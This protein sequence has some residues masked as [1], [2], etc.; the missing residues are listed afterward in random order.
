MSCIAVVY[1]VISSTPVEPTVLNH[2]IS[3]VIR[4]F[5]CAGT[6]IPQTLKFVQT[7]IYSKQFHYEIKPMPSYK[8][9]RIHQNDTSTIH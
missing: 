7:A 5:P 8:T 1:K 4:K 3:T 6:T 2:L 9:Y